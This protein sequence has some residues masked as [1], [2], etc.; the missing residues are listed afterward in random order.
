MKA[1]VSW[2]I[3][4]QWSCS[5]SVPAHPP[6]SRSS[7]QEPTKPYPASFAPA[8]TA[9]ASASLVVASVSCIYGLGTPQSYLDRPVKLEVGE[10]IDR[11]TLSFHDARLAWTAEPGEFDIMVGTASDAIRLRGVLTLQ[12]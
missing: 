4:L 6:L 1:Q 5:S 11:D 9:R 8:T 12:D 2:S 3:P 7:D 10:E